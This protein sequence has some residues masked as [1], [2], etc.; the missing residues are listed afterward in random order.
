MT[1]RNLA[2]IP[3]LWQTRQ[4]VCHTKQILSLFLYDGHADSRLRASGVRECRGGWWKPEPVHLGNCGVFDGLLFHVVAD[5]HILCLP[6]VLSH[7]WLDIDAWPSRGTQS[8]IS[9]RSSRCVH[10][11]IRPAGGRRT[12]KRRRPAWPTFSPWKPKWIW[13]GERASTPMCVPHHPS[14]WCHA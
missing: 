9:I 8:L 12:E 6:G 10:F 13:P 5:S 7:A 4:C 11:A 3:M 14:S 2:A 1:T